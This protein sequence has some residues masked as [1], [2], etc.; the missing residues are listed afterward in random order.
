[1]PK[2]IFS[3]HLSSKQYQLISV[4]LDFSRDIDPYTTKLHC[5][6]ICGFSVNIMY[7]TVH[8]KVDTCVC[9]HTCGMR[10]YVNNLSKL[11]SCLHVHHT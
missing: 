4:Q 9:Q 6:F 5:T 8:I 2:L 10:F 7:S 1:M 3:R 11:M